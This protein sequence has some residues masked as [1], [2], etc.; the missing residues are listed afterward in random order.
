[1]GMCSV[2]WG[3][4][5]VLSIATPEA[6]PTAAHRYLCTLLATVTICSMMVY[7]S[8]RIVRTIRAA[9]AADDGYAD[10]YRDG[11]DA[12]PGAPAVSRLVPSR[13]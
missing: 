11:L 2:A 7:L 9:S 13:R 10:G 4:F 5:G 6:L 1:M 8:A 3:A 12:R